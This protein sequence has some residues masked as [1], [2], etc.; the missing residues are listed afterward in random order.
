MRILTSIL[1]FC[2]AALHAGAQVTPP[3]P[4]PP[5]SI[6]F[7]L[8]AWSRDLPELAFGKEQTTE[9]LEQGSRSAVMDYFGPPLLNFTLAGKKTVNG[10]PPP[11]IASITIPPGVSKLT[12]LV[13]PSTGDRLN[14]YTI[15]EDG[16]G[17]PP[18]TARLHN[19]SR[20]KLRV[21]YNKREH[22]ELDPGASALLKANKDTIV[23]RV[24]G[25]VKAEWR[26]L[27]NNVIE[28][29]QARGTNVLL[30]RGSLGGGIGLFPLPD[31]PAERTPTATQGTP[32]T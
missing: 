8:V 9:A 23:I 26:E 4:A 27:F 19:L 29:P 2:V 14:I 15:S 30:I 10:V 11:V 5:I 25:I 1:A 6:K 31:W 21:I 22:V 32:R 12:L 16:E 17:V 3:P 13:L 7:R 18:S 28:I 20:E 24:G